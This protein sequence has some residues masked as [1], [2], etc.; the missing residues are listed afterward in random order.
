MSK[1]LEL[2]PPGQIEQMAKEM[3]GLTG[4][5]YD[6]EVLEYLEENFGILMIENTTV[7]VSKYNRKTVDGST[8]YYD[9][10][11]QFKLENGKAIKVGEAIETD[12]TKMVPELQ[13]WIVDFY[14]NGIIRVFDTEEGLHVCIN[15]TAVKQSAF[16]GAH[17]LS[18]YFIPKQGN[19]TASI[20]ILLHYYEDGNVQMNCH[21]S[22]TVDPL[23]EVNCKS[24]LE[25]IKTVEQKYHEQVKT[26]DM[27]D[28]FKNLRR[29][30]P[31]TKQEIEWEKVF[32]I[33]I[34]KW[35]CI[36]EKVNQ[37]SFHSLFVH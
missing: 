21:K 20:K 32:Y 22:F 37:R 14:P 6:S 29:Q 34:G 4:K 1:L 23:K 12:Y 30:L 9:I 11:G 25:V 36:V 3:T 2:A 35:L 17:W 19:I 15:S 8:I 33:H 13:Q 27:T 31:L 10:N 5:N 28:T 7:M 24:I 16:W 18:H 26:A